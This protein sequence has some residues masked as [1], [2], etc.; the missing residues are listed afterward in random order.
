MKAAGIDLAG[1]SSNPS[2]F[3]VLSRHKFTCCLLYSDGDILKAVDKC[4]PRIVAI[5]AP[6][7]FPHR[8]NLREADRVL[9]HRGYRVF[10]PT[11]GP[12]K[13]LTE[14]GMKLA[15]K[16]RSKFRVIETHPRTSGK[17]LF[18]TPDRKTWLRELRREGFSFDEDAGEHEIDAMLVALTGSLHLQGKTEAVGLPREGSMIIPKVGASA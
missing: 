2:G 17:I 10:P 9:I 16:L 5:D 12:M 6:L 11:F 1:K 13:S 15:G 4:S 7:S 14:R 3:A 8:G 18:G